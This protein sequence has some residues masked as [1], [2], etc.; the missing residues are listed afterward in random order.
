MSF[1]IITLLAI[2]T[3]AVVLFVGGWLRVDVV[4]LLVLS[5]LALT[6]LVTP[7]EALAGFS[8]PAVVTVWAMFILSAG[9]TRTGIAH[10]L[11]QPLQRF[12]KR[13]E[14]LL[15]VA[16]MVAASLLSA[17][18]N[19]VTVAAILLPAAMELARRSGRP[20]SRLL[21][22]CV[23]LCQGGCLLSVAARSACSALSS[24]CLNRRRQ[25]DV[26]SP[27]GCGRAP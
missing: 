7:Q 11:G 1:Q 27:G 21:M 14:A 24:G 10:R 16:L 3:V 2:V 4:G 19:T 25:T 18:I 26:C 15:M 13:S 6:G 8:S 22:P 5:A 23:R 9:L 17:L 20:P 12:T